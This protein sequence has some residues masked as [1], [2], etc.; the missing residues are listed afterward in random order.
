[1]FV[2]RSSHLVIWLVSVITLLLVISRRNVD[3][4]RSQVVEGL[5][6]AEVALESVSYVPAAC[7]DVFNCLL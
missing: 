2:V 6:E 5:A 7:T 1:M 3:L 4:E